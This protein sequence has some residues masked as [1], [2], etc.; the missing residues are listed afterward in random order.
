M[1]RRELL[2]FDLPCVQF[3]G[4][5]MLDWPLIAIM[6]LTSDGSH[7]HLVLQAKREMPAANK[8]TINWFGEGPPV[9][10]A[11]YLPALTPALRL[12]NCG[13]LCSACS[14]GSRPSALTLCCCCCCYSH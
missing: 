7:P 9:A 10:A 11:E 6:S 3:K 4:V 2:G 14:M 5:L 12:V 13:A 8:D 1:L